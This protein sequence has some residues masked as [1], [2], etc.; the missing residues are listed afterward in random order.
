M[1]TQEHEGVE[2]ELIVT[3]DDGHSGLSG[4]STRGRRSDPDDVVVAEGRHKASEGGQN[5]TVDGVQG[6]EEATEEDQDE[7]V[8]SGMGDVERDVADSKKNK[9]DKHHKISLSPVREKGKD[10]EEGTD[11]NLEEI[12]DGDF[13]GQKETTLCSDLKLGCVYTVKV[14]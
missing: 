8:A 4:W 14:M 12:S 11:S 9:K 5:S 3:G 1:A 13:F 7:S 2:G 6:D 10:L